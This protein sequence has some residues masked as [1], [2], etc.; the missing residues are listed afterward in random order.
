[1]VNSSA[2]L[3]SI[4]PAYAEAIFAG[5]KTVELRRRRPGFPE[6]TTVL[7]YSSAPDQVVRGAF[8]SGAVLAA[9]PEDLWAL[10]H[11]QAA[12]SR[13]DFDA[14]FGGC[15]IGYAIQVREPR[16]LTPAPLPVHPP[17][18]YFVLRPDDEN[19]AALR[20]LAAEA[21]RPKPSAASKFTSFMCSPPALI[22]AI[23]RFTATRLPSRRD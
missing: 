5:N 4:R 3:M 19:H 22:A 10:V 16:S 2:I 12:I 17:Q 23:T 13:E 7:V 21:T 15:E 20:N 8:R 6:G 9:P 1:M 14:Y 18:S 11:D